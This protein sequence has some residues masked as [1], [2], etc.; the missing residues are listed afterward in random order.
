MSTILVVEDTQDSYDLIADALGDEHTLVHARTGPEGIKMAA[1]VRPD[2]I[3]LDM[4][5]PELDGLSVVRRL[6]SMEELKATPVVAVT[7]N[8]MPQDREICLAAGCDD[9]LSKPI[10]I[11]ALVELVNRILSTDPGARAPQQKNPQPCQETSS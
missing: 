2:L 6:R 3:L 5:L 1:C 10:A 4:R 8:A 7:A 11:H 9:Y